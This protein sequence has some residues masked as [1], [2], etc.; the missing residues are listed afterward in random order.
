MQLRA[1]TTREWC[2]Q[3]TS[4]DYEFDIALG[5]RKPSRGND[6]YHIIYNCKDKASLAVSFFFLTIFVADKLVSF[7]LI[8]I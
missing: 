7:V 5:D 1:D 3:K 2:I 8:E 4:S 6:L